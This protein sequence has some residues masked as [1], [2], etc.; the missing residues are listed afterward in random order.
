[1][2]FCQYLCLILFFSLLTPF[3][4]GYLLNFTLYKGNPQ[5]IMIPSSAYETED[6]FAASLTTSYV[7]SSGN[8]DASSFTVTNQISPFCNFNPFQI[9]I[10]PLIQIA[11]MNTSETFEFISVSNYVYF[12]DNSNNLSIYNISADANGVYREILKINQYE[13]YFTANSNSFIKFF[14]DSGSLLYLM[15]DSGLNI[16][17]LSDPG[18]PVRLTTLGFNLRNQSSI[19]TVDYY[20]GCFVFLMQSQYVDMHCINNIQNGFDV[21]LD[22]GDQS[23]QAVLAKQNIS[24]NAWNFTDLL[25]DENGVLLIS[26]YNLGIIALDISNPKQVNWFGMQVSI[27]RVTMLKKSGQSLMVTRQFWN[28]PFLEN[29]F[30]EYYTKLDYQNNQFSFDQNAAY[31][32]DQTPITAMH[33]ARNYVLLLQSDA[34][35]LFRHSIS[36]LLTQNLTPLQAFLTGGMIGLHH[37]DDPDKNL[38][39]AIYPYRIAIYN[40]DIMNITLNCEAPMEVNKGNYLLNFSVWST[41]CPEMNNSVLNGTSFPACVYQIPALAAVYD[42]GTTSSSGTDQTG[43]I[44]GLVVGLFFGLVIIIFCGCYLIRISKKYEELH[45]KRTGMAMS[46]PVNAGGAGIIGG[47]EESE[48]QS[49]EPREFAPVGQQMAGMDNR[50]EMADNNRT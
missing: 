22:L 37:L 28:S 29:H 3:S 30:E 5:T 20:K 9:T 43:L 12:F 49:N 45:E 19:Q 50:L 44:A 14:Q 40:I 32:L 36:K 48:K 8:G 11:M 25:I 38:F 23:A 13:T 6:P 47:F 41:T 31:L 35:N 2:A 39:I 1:M 17:N 15:I 4:Q 26:D 16:Y 27:T 21:T 46:G 10:Y 18:F 7:L 33:A 34:M 42:S 24:F